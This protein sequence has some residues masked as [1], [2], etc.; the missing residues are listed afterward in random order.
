MVDQKLL[1]GNGE[2]Y[3]RAS[4]RHVDLNV[5]ISET[6]DGVLVLVHV[7]RASAP[8]QCKKA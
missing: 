5:I 8:N 3:L 2:I 4:D 6:K 1:S 7:G